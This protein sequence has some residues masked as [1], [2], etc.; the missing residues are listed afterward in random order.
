MAARWITAFIT[1][2]AALLLAACDDDAAPTPVACTDLKSLSLA[3]ATIAS[4]TPV[5]A[6]TFSP[7]AG[8]HTCATI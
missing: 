7:A 3:G 8:G 5:P 1:A 4:A 2:L 6:G